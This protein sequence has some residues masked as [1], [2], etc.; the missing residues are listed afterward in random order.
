MTLYVVGALIAAFNEAR[1]G[2]SAMISFGPSSPA[3]VEGVFS[4]VQGALD[5][6]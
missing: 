2:E 5:S 6:A 4:E 3:C 1:A